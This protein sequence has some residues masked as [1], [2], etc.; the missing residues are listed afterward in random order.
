VL[1][2][3]VDDALTGDYWSITLPNELA[4][5][6]AKSPT[7][8][9]YI[10]ALNIL[11]ADALLSTGKVR[12]RLD[13]AVTAKKGIERH[14]LFPRAYLRDKLGIKDNKDINQIANMAL[15]EWSD[16]I[17]IS[18]TAPADYWPKQLAKKNLDADVLARQCYL[19]ALPDG[20]EEMSYGDFLAQ[21]RHLMGQVVKDAF[22][23]LRQ[24]GYQ[25]TY[26]PVD[27]TSAASS[28]D[29]ADDRESGYELTT[30]DL[31]SL[32][33]LMPDALLTGRVDDVE[34]QARLLADGTIEFDGEV[35]N[36]LSA[37]GKVAAGRTVN[38][39][40][41]WGTETDEGYRRLRRIRRMYA[42]G[43]SGVDRGLDDDED[44]A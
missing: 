38:G 1:N 20:W 4:T 32:G 18:D 14:H 42:S 16:N 7:L 25:P 39:W 37:A 28:S 17:D 41:F 19:H 3:V 40:Y 35:Y 27:I 36:S 9:A 6:A 21:R 11:D 15:V 2:K 30:S 13:P 5:S 10:A 43:Q 8:L 22:E 31:I 34:V 24:S 26:P 44:T 33:V 12:S 29:K 23:T